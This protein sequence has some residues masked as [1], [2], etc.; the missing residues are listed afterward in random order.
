MNQQVVDQPVI[1]QQ[2]LPG[3][4]YTSGVPPQSISARLPEFTF[5]RYHNALPQQ[6]QIPGQRPSQAEL[7]PNTNQSNGSPQRTSQ[8]FARGSLRVF[9]TRP[10]ARRA[11]NGQYLTSERDRLQNSTAEDRFLAAGM[12]P[13]SQTWGST[14]RPGIASGRRDG[15]PRNQHLTNFV[16]DV[17]AISQ[18]YP[19]ASDDQFAS[20]LQRHLDSERR[21]LEIA[22]EYRREQ[23]HQRMWIRFCHEY[24]RRELG[25]ADEFSDDVLDW[26]LVVITVSIGEQDGEHDGCTSE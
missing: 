17:I 9:T 3:N 2:P 12:A 13:P 10:I 16:E 18:R 6:Q 26:L 7:P 8:I 20:L 24:L 11:N 5:R 22:I 1:N 21:L 23:Y 14:R 4:T 25:L 19:G 15:E